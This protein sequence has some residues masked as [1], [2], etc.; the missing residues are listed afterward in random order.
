[1]EHKAAAPAAGVSLL[2]TERIILKPSKAV[3]FKANYLFQFLIPMK[4]KLFLLTKKVA[5]T[6][7]AHL[8]HRIKKL[9][10]RYMTAEQVMNYLISLKTP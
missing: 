7:K 5:G 9:R 3:L 4:P 2:L 8:R 10:V 1:M 6:I